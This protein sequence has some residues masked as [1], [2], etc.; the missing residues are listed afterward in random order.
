MRAADNRAGAKL[1]DARLAELVV[2]VESGRIPERQATSRRGP[3]V[4]E[5]AGA[6]QEANRPYRDRRSGDWVG[7]SPKTARTVADNF[8]SHIL[9]AIG[10]WAVDQVS[11]LDLDRLYRALEDETGLSPSVVVRCHGQIRA[12]FNWGLRKKLVAANPALGADPPRVKPRQLKIPSMDQVRA[13][14]EVAT[15]EFA[16]FVQ[17]AATVGARRGTLVALRWGDV[18][19]DRATITFSRSIAQSVDGQVEKGTKADR[20]YTV[21][22]GQAT[23][24]VLSEH[25]RR[26]VETALSVGVPL[27]PETF[28]FSDDGGSAHWSL[29]WPSHAWLRYSRRAGVIHLRLHDLRHGLSAYLSCGHWVPSGSQAGSLSPIHPRVVIGPSLWSGLHVP[30]P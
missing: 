10:G 8:R 20:S 12:M 3:T 1:A 13:V 27:G 24:A 18:H 29:A 23:T 15:P 17:L 28:V 7:W 14:Q 9:P 22:L 2:A 16:A 11:G 21:A 26:A 5:L 6:W 19:L 25:R 4:A 30:H